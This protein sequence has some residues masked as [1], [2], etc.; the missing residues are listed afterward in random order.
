[1]PY[2]MII[3]R[4]ERE[5]YLIPKVGDIFKVKEV[6]EMELSDCIIVKMFPFLPEISHDSTRLKEKKE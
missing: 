4:D 5:K 2:A 3:Y 1:M 6:K